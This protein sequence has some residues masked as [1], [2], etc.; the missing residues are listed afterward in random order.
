VPVDG[1]AVR[2]CLAPLKSAAGK[3]VTTIEGLEKD[4]QLHPM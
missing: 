3:S 4:G 1:E 2:S